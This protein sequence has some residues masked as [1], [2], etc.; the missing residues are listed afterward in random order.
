MSGTGNT[1]GSGLK[2]AVQRGS[3][4]NFHSDALGDAPCAS[5]GGR[6]PFTDAVRVG[7]VSGMQTLRAAV[8]WDDTGKYFALF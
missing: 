2:T 1:E 8:I 5:Q 7:Q 4:G 3:V 6:M